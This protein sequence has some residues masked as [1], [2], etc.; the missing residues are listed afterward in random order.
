MLEH[1]TEL[2]I[3]VYLIFF[4]KTQLSVQAEYIINWM[5]VFFLLLVSLVTLHTGNL[6]GPAIA[7]NTGRKV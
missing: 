4:V 7:E 6:R 1:D 3:K 5:N 2:F